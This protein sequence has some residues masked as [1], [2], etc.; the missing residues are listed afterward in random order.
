[1]T[2][3]RSL[4]LSCMSLIVCIAVA[5]SGTSVCQAAGFLDQLGDTA[6]KIGGEL[7][8]GAGK[9]G[10]ELSTGARKLGED[11]GVLEKEQPPHTPAPQQRS[12]GQP[13]VANQSAVAPPSAK[14]PG[15]VVSRLKKI[16]TELD[17][18]ERSFI[19]NGGKPTNSTHNRLESA[20]MLKEEIDK[21]YAGQF[22]PDH[23]EVAP[24]YR[25]YEQLAASLTVSSTPAADQPSAD[26]AATG[27]EVSCEDWNA[28]LRTFTQGERALHVY[29]TEDEAQMARWKAAFDEST[30][31]LGHYHSSSYNQQSCPEAEAT[32]RQLNNYRDNFQAIYAD[33]QQKSAAA[34]AS[35]GDIVFSTAP[36][37]PAAPSGLRDHFQAGDYIYGLIRATQPWAAI[38]NNDREAQIRVDV[39]MDGKKIHAQLVTVRDPALL[40]GQNL[41]FDVAPAPDAMTAYRNPAVEYGKSTATMRQG[42]NELTYH[43]GQL[44]PGSHTVHFIIQYY[45]TTYAEGQFIIEGGH[46]GAYAKLHESIAAGVAQAVTLPVP[47]MVDKAL[48]SEMEKVLGNAGWPPIHRIN[49]VDK[50]WWID[51]VSGGDSPV[52]SRHIAAAAL[53]QG[54][55]GYFY[56]I[57]TF[58]Q[59]R[60]ITGG[61][62]PLYLSH[63]GDPVPVPQENI[64]K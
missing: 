19:D 47:K 18:A 52:A 26:L 59:D 39:T 5:L 15:G 17:K 56:K 61:F 63:Q 37:D 36:I 53:A 28:R 3:R 16:S 13:E 22:S 32:V 6:K 38:Y 30:T 14:L 23:P 34:A 25:R 64:D 43:L 41:L 11:V 46:F 49:I 35:L 48:L 10:E 7:A 8:D 60:L 24:V 2:I 44:A 50:D 1:M 51:R 58:H 27:A 20:R 54:N 21:G 29:P 12:E 62:G 31:T 42:P 57:C 9:I 55:D 33:Y 40:T 45:G 4:F